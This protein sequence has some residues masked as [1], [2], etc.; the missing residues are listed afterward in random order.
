MQKIICTWFR[1]LKK[2]FFI[3]RNRERQGAGKEPTADRDST[4]SRQTQANPANRV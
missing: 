2:K 3:L 4:D 1:D